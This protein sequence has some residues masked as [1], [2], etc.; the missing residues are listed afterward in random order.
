MDELLFYGGGDLH[1]TF[2]EHRRRARSAVGSMTPSQMNAASDDE[3]VASVV[4]Q[5]RIEPLQVHDDRAESDHQESQVNV[6]HDPRRFRR[7]DG[8]PLIVKGNQITVRIPF[9]G[10]PDLFK[11]QPSSY[12]LNPHVD[13]SRSKGSI[14]ASCSSHWPC[15]LIRGPRSSTGGYRAN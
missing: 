10:D 11:L 7:D 12:T 5:F 8:R 9:S 3:V 2:E 4:E 6:S 1:A 15:P 14:P 13:E